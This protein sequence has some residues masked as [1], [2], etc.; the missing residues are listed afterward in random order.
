MKTSLK[1]VAFG[2]A[3]V[4]SIVA[5]STASAQGKPGAADRAARKE[6]LKEHGAIMRQKLES[7]SPE[8]KAALK[9]YRDAYKAEKMSLR[10]QIKAGTLDKK[11][12]A[13][14]LKAWREAN[15]PAKKS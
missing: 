5:A 8:Q 1:M 4:L 6:R 9:A 2:S 3:L 12:A 10:A 7:L 15:R 13:E 11:T 14:Q